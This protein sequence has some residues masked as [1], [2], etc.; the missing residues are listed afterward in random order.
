[1]D[2]PSLV[3]NPRFEVLAAALSV[4]GVSLDGAGDWGAVFDDAA[5]SVLSEIGTTVADGAFE[6]PVP[7]RAEELGP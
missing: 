4:L 2:A 7:P 3:G 1:M 5:E 6:L